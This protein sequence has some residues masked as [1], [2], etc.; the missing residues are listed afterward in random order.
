MA[1]NAIKLV[2]EHFRYQ[3][4]LWKEGLKEENP[5]ITMVIRTLIYGVRPSGNL[6]GAGFVRVAEYAEEHRPHLAKGA[7]VVKHD[8]YVDDSVASFDSLGEC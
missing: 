7:S 6:T 4:Y 3:Q 1:Y 5:T 2:P 8:T